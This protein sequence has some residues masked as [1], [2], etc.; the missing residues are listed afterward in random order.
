MATTI[1]YIWA[2]TQSQERERE[3][4][5]NTHHR[6][7]PCLATLGIEAN[8][9]SSRIVQYSK[10]KPDMVNSHHNQTREHQHKV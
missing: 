2:H 1:N 7:D 9:S 10:E 4:E 8:D 3:R 6:E 5:T